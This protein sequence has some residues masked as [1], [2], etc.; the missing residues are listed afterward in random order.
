MAE[1]PAQVPPTGGDV[2]VKICGLTRVEDALVAVDAGADLIG[3]IFYPPSPRHVS[4][5]RARTMVRAVRATGVPVRIVGVTVNAPKWLLHALLEE[6]G[7]D[8]V[9]C[10]GDEPPDRVAALRGRGFKAVRLTKATLEESAAFLDIG[11]ADGPHLLVDAAVPGAYGGTGHRADWKAAALL[12]RQ[13]PILL[14]GG[15]TPENVM[16][17]IRQVRP[18]GV[19]VSSGVELRP[20]QKDPARVR[21]FIARVR[22]AVREAQRDT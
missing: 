9:Q 10:H 1:T 2:R 5:T 14:A 4:L 22:A 13:G 18:W 11:P 8:W 12:A 20:G 15:L 3:M 16:A 6:V 7:V 19:D 21:A 17:A